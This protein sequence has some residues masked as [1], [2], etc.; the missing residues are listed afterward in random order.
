MA[1]RFEGW[2]RPCIHGW[3]ERA[4]TAWPEAIAVSRPDGSEAVSF[5]GLAAEAIRTAAAL[6][7][8][9]PGDRV[10]IIMR[11]S[12]QT[13]R[14]LFAAWAC[15]A[16][17][18]PI[19]PRLGRQQRQQRLERVPLHVLVDPGATDP[20]RVLRAPAGRTGEPRLDP[21]IPLIMFTS[22]STGVPKAVQISHRNLRAAA[23]ANAARV[24]G[25]TETVWY[26]PLPLEHMG[27]LM[28]IVRAPLYGMTSIIDDDLDPTRLSDRLQTSGATAISL[29]PTMLRRWLSALDAVPEA[30]EAVLVGG[31]AT[32]PALVQQSL[33]RGVPLFV[34]YGMTETTSQVA[35]AT[36][37]MLAADPATVGP[38]LD[39]VTLQTLD[40]TGAPTEPG[41]VG[42]VVVR[43]PMLT[44]GYIDGNRSAFGTGGFRTGDEGI[45]DTR[46]WVRIVGRADRRIVSG[47]ETVD[48]QVT[49]RVIASVP[50]VGDVWVGG[51]VD[52]TWGER[53]VAVVSADDV[54]QI[55]ALTTVVAEALDPAHRP[56]AIYLTDAL[57]RTPTGTVD[58]RAVRRS[59]AE[60]DPLWH[61]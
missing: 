59:I 10:G 41:G 9:G 14:W 30:L 43:G 57:P 26:D 1:E 12:P 20:I 49:E 5:A 44:P 27:G 17:V 60:T 19:G 13:V 53:V 21:E 2:V 42:V 33:A 55:D 25:D 46:G 18:V 4:A 37:A 48:P 31:A 56:R 50:W 36:P 32:P 3:L 58:A 24:T 28:P 29:V 34:T 11:R 40:A 54:P 51:L 61:A 22:G 7:P 6:R 52:D 8:L 39:G 16:T 23:Q 38:P 15:H 35:T 47:G 45:I